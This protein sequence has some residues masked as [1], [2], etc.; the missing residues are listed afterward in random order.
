M[1]R[2]RTIRPTRNDAALTLIMIEAGCQDV[3]DLVRVHRPRAVLFDLT[4]P[5]SDFAVPL[6]RQ[7]PGLLLIGVDPSR[8]KCYSS[9]ATLCR[10]SAWPIWSMSSV[11][12]GQIPN[13]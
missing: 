7:Q 3:A 10:R 11:R 5:Q 12:K 1:R 6:L 13:H 4:M 9:P 2:T 8:T